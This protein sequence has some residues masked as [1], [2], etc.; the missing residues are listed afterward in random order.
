MTIH[1]KKTPTEL[2]FSA[3]KPAFLIRNLKTLKSLKLNHVVS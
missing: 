1:D 2:V 3:V